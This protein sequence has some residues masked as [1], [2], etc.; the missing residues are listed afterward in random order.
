MGK[1]T[2]FLEIEREERDYAPVEER[3]KNYR[4]FVLPLSDEEVRKQG[5]RCMDC[6]VP[7]CHGTPNVAGC[8][9]TAIA[10]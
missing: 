8:S 4:E 7:Y 9:P 3:V 5:A 10:M 2:G 1:V 6:G